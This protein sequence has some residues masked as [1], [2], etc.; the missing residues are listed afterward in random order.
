MKGDKRRR[1]DHYLWPTKH[2]YCPRRTK[3]STVFKHGI[4]QDHKTM[5]PHKM[6]LL[7]SSGRASEEWERIRRPQSRNVKVLDE[8]KGVEARIRKTLN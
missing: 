5:W 7:R 8:P 6:C 2:N 3:D 4:A 1:I